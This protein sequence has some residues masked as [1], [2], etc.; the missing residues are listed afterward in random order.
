MPA[1]PNRK[2]VLQIAFSIVLQGVADS[3][4]G[5]IFIAVGA[6]GKR[7]DDCAPCAF[8]LYHFLEDSEST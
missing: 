6:Y 5:F 1:P 8:K 2:Y 4:Y 3:E 7:S